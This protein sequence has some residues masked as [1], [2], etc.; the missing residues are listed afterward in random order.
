MLDTQI[1]ALQGDHPTTNTLIIAEHFGKKHKDVLRALRELVNDCDEEFGRRNF[2]PTPYYDSQGKQQNM[3]TLTRDGFML[4]SMGFTGANATRLKIAFIDAFNKMEAA[5]HQNAVMPGQVEA[6]QARRMKEELLAAKPQWCKVKRYLDMGLN[7]VEICRLIGK[8]RS[9]V[10][11]M[12][13]KMAACGIIQ[14]TVNPLL[15]AAGK[16]GN[17]KRLEMMGGGH[18]H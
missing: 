16:R 10:R 3:Y 8:S 5:L 13:D 11:H 7:Q 14:R 4:L 12:L 2:A 1:V 15:S 17:R 6:V 9:A 18:V